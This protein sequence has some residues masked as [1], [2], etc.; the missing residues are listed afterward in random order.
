MKKA[1]ITGMYG[2]DGSYVAELL[3]AKGYEI[4]GIVHAPMSE[5]SVRIR[6]ELRDKGIVIETTDIP[7]TDY[8]LLKEEIEAFRPDEI[9]HLAATHFSA[10]KADLVTESSLFVNNITATSNILDICY[11][12]HKDARIVTAGSCLMY[13]A[14]HTD[15]QSEKTPFASNTYYGIAKITENML[16]RMFRDRGLYACTAILYNHES[17]RRAETFVTRKIVKNMVRIARGEQESFTLGSLDAMKDWGFAG[18]YARAMHLMLDQSVPKDYVLATGSLH[19]IGEFV[20]ECAQQLQIPDWH[21]CVQVNDRIL[22]R[23]NSATLKGDSSLAARELGWKRTKGF[24]EIIAE[25]I[26]EEK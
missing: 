21:R 23:K 19:S 3:K 8:A 14:T 13:D 10:E 22:A 7:L 1:L 4:R 25:M 18:D 16:V 5:N 26:S 6:Q 20:E 12:Y 17:H 11:N 24:A 15:E 2:Q 9:Y